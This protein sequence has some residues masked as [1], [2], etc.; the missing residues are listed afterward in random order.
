MEK[1]DYL[2]ANRDNWDERVAIHWASA[3]YNVRRYIED[4]EAISDVVEFDRTEIGDVAGKRLLH[5]QCHI[6]N[7]T[8]SW[9]RLG[10]TVTGVD[11]SP[12]AIDAARRLS[13]ESGTPGR[14][15]VS[16]LYDSP[17]HLNEEFDVVYTSVGAICWLPD[18][19]GWARVVST[20]LKPG[21]TFYM[22]EGHP[23][24]WGI[25]WDEENLLS[26][27]EPYFGGTGPIGYEEDTTYAGEGKLKNTVQYNFKHA[28]SETVTALINSGLRIE[29]FREHQFCEWRGI[30]HLRQDEDGKWRLPEPRDRLP[31]M[32]S[33]RAVKA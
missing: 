32:F 29:L 5:L 20:F 8:L 26:I 12:K 1:T 31:L 17:S 13:R 27:A 11:F 6:G 24:M 30:P 21:G 23:I 7:D 22:R 10:A 25:D 15:L 18:I 14:F 16:E 28:L 19:G 4:P 9:A 2:S 3:E 33:I